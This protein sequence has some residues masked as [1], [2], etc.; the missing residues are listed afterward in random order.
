V[1]SEYQS[2]VKFD[3]REAE[4]NIDSFARKV[5]SLTT[6]ARGAKVQVAS[7][8]TSLTAANRS[9][10][11][12][13]INAAA[14]AKGTLSFG[15]A[16]TSAASAA[17]GL[18]SAL[19]PAKLSATTRAIS[20]LDSA[21]RSV[22]TS[23][24]GAARSAGSLASGMNKASS[25]IGTT[26]ERLKE[27]S[28]WAGRAQKSVD[29]LNASLGSGKVTQA[30]QAF[31]SVVGSFRA[32]SARTT[33]FKNEIDKVVANLAKVGTAGTKAAAGIDRFTGAL[34]RMLPK[35]AQA[36][37]GVNDLA[38]AL[39]KIAGKYTLS[40]V[41]AGSFARAAGQAGNAA[42]KAGGQIS[43]AA[44]RAGQFGAASAA[45]GNQLSGM[46]SRLVELR[47]LA[48]YYIAGLGISKLMEYADTINLISARLA[49][50]GNNYVTTGVLERKLQ[51]ISI[52]TRSEYEANAK[53]FVKL[54]QA[55]KAYGV[56]QQ[57]ALTV[58]ENV[59]KALKIS[60]ATNAEAANSTLQLSQAFAS[61]KF[62]GDELRSVL[63]NSPRLAQAF[64]EKLAYLGV[65]LSNIRKFAKEGK[66]GI[67]EMVKVLSDP[68]LTAELSAEFAKIPMTMGQALQ[69]AATKLMI[70]IGE[71]DKA[72]G[73]SRKVVA[74]I[75]LV[76]DHFNDIAIAVGLASVAIVAS[77]IPAI[78]GA[79]N[80]SKVFVAGKFAK[81]F[82]DIASASRVAAVSVVGLGAAVRGVAAGGGIAAIGTLFKSLGGTGLAA[83]RGISAV[84]MRW[85]PL[86]VAAGVGL[87]LFKSKFRPI[88]DEAATT[89]DY[90]VTGMTIAATKIYDV[91]SW[92]FSKPFALLEYNIN[93]S[94]SILDFMYRS[95]KFI[96]GT[97]ADAPG[98]IARTV[99][100]TANVLT[101]GMAGSPEKIDAGRNGRAWAATGLGED[102]GRAVKGS[103]WNVQANIRAAERRQADPRYQALSD[104]IL[105]KLDKTPDATIPKPTDTGGGKGGRGGAEKV[106]RLSEYGRD[107][108]DRIANIRSEFDE[109]PRAIDRAARAMRQLADIADDLERKKPPNYQVLIDQV[110]EAGTVVEDS[111]NRPLR[112][113]LRDAEERI[114]TDAA[115]LKGGE[116]W[117]VAMQRVVDLEREGKVLNDEQLQSVLATVEAERRRSMVIRDQ[118]A[119]IDAYV[120]S[121]ND[122]RS[123]LEGTVAGALKGEFK[124]G[125]FFSS[126]ADT[127]RNL[128]AKV[129]TEKLFGDALRSVEDSI[130]GGNIVEDASGKFARNLDNGGEA[131]G[132]FAQ[133]VMDA[134]DKIS[135]VAPA[136][137][138]SAALPGLSSGS[139]SGTPTLT[140]VINVASTVAA[141]VVKTPKL[142]TAV[143]VLTNAASN[144]NSDITV[145]GRKRTFFEEFATSYKDSLKGTAESI[146][147]FL[148]PVG[149]VLGEAATSLGINTTGLGKT[150]GKVAAGAETGSAIGGLMSAIGIKTSETGAAIGGG[151]GKATGI[152]GGEIVGAIL[153]GIV[154]GLFK[155]DKVGT[156]VVSNV[157]D[158]VTASGNNDQ[159]KAAVQQVGTGVQGAISNIAQTLGAEVGEFKVSIGK[160]NDYFRVS[161]MG[162]TRVSEK[163]YP[164]KNRSDVIYDGKD[165]GEALRVAIQN[166]IQDGA[167]K[168]LSE[169]S[170]R[171]LKTF[172]NIDRALQ[173]ASTIESVKK[174]AAAVR[175]PI[176]S[177]FDEIQKQISAS[178]KMFD[179]AGASAA[180]YADLALVA[181][182]QIKATLDQ[183]ISGYRSLL[184]SLKTGDLSYASPINKLSAANTKFGGLETKIASGDF[185]FT[186]EEF[187]SA[188][189]ALQQLAREVYG[190]TPDFAAYQQR[191]I[192]ATEKVIGNA[193]ATANSYQPVVDALGRQNEIMTGIGALTNDY[194]AR[195]VAANAANGA[196]PMYA[197]AGNREFGYFFNQASF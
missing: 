98:I 166:A 130:L 6:A 176:K 146:G 41:G 90:L 62:Q 168:G 110:M 177:A 147:K 31:N 40:V 89:G 137:V 154:G 145:T 129:I 84:F 108:A 72:G 88:R 148:K 44:S 144:D 26:K 196:D 85:P 75:G 111:L 190:S 71:L 11:S 169:T 149:K 183:Q 49:I 25:S 191:L 55:G 29:N 59:A 14:A 3:S 172:K 93:N 162:S 65:N 54:A 156:A 109:Q 104:S 152:P 21:T 43:Q 37:I 81:Y 106:D 67:D 184:E 160:W 87:V 139:T 114:Q 161:A 182:T 60:G 142:K 112:E 91:L 19:A 96:I 178:K 18:M 79:A 102:F 159:A 97:A 15:R 143:G 33:T 103:E 61:G 186:Q 10:G 48:Q 94:I 165:E 16:A 117:A 197:G 164:D 77:Y 9:V 13:A 175:D 22:R 1:P 28:S 47:S 74:F 133:A 180:D 125:D 187:T 83:L 78:L 132:S 151:I 56:S 39:Q 155:K 158:I 42:T 138:G 95:I 107:A 163:R 127:F 46:A 167:I 92:A 179:E 128:T 195:L 122:V 192:E 194:L 113:Y 86:L 193:E 34:G 58:T 24:D 45:A 116:D 188:G 50:L 63:E 52:D 115:F 5:G 51:K 173:V 2:G 76:A 53:L 189:Q 174:Q 120:Q 7:F 135:G 141:G 181:Q 69:N 36:A 80:A 4:K 70:Y 82:I 100:K 119:I 17:R 157:T 131:V 27:L 126:I 8:G 64:S 35:L 185:S 123:A 171:V 57:T 140:S 105:M 134:R 32:A 68:T 66:I 99:S 136:A 150:L 170:D 30:A 153:G 118:K 23:L 73:I 38:L 124:I 121:V 101:G 20:G 12:I